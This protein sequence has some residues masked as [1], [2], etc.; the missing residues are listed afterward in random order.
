MHTNEGIIEMVYSSSFS[1]IGF[2]FY[3][4]SFDN[5]KNIKYTEKVI[6]TGTFILLKIE[7]SKV[8]FLN[9]GKIKF[10]WHTLPY[11][12]EFGNLKKF[13][14]DLLF[15]FFSLEFG[16]NIINNK[17]DQKKSNDEIEN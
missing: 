17:N 12:C 7:F 9:F 10:N 3:V 4:I 8:S 15:N 5:R 6:F 14:I 13:F 11:L 16:I 1:P 2:A